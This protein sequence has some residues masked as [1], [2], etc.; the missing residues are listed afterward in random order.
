MTAY[1]ISRAAQADLRAI[2]T[3]THKQWGRPQADLYVRDIFDALTTLAMNPLLGRDR[4][5]VKAGYRRH[6]CGRHMLWYKYVDGIVILSRV[7]HSGMDV[8]RHL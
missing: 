1:K 4:H 3:F 5:H 6:I 2:W 7:L 8:R